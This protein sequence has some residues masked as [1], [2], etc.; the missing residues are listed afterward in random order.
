LRVF[1]EWVAELIARHA[2]PL[3]PPL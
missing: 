1:I 2:P 3:H